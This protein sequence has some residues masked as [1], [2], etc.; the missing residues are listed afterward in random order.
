MW[1]EYA[2]QWYDKHPRKTCTMLCASEFPAP[3]I[4]NCPRD[5]EPTSRK[6]DTLATS[7]ERSSP[8]PVGMTKKHSPISP[9]AHAWYG[10][11]KP[12]VCNLIPPTSVAIASKGDAP[13]P[14]CHYLL[15]PSNV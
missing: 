7:S 4:A 10:K 11:I 9:L 15:Q 3:S 1:A 2:E 8:C 6:E 14:P 5:M 13:P 12:R